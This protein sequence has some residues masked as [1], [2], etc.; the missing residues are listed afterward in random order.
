ML[1]NKLPPDSVAYDNNHLLS[2][3][4]L[5]VRNLGRA[6]PNSSHLGSQAIESYVGWGCS[7]LKVWLGQEDPL[8]TGSPK[9]V[10]VK[11][12][13][14]FF[15]TR[16]S[17]HSTSVVPLL[18]WLASPRTN[19]PRDQ[20]EA[21]ETLQCFVWFNLVNHTPSLSSCATDCVVTKFHPKGEKM[22]LLHLERGRSITF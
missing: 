22:K 21:Q 6:L 13:P 14:Q 1:H 7:H 11:L 12:G 8:H 20:D 15:F 4:T 9:L 5:L 19:N 17:P 16:A 10:L 2:F 18:W 3:R